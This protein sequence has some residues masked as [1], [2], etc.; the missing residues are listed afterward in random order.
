[1]ATDTSSTPRIVIFDFGGVLIDWNPRYVFR[2]LFETE[3]QMEWF[4]SN[5]C[6]SDWNEE[7]DAG[8]PIAKATEERIALWPEYEDLI[9][10]Y[11]GRWVE[12][13]GGPLTETVA[14][15][16]ELKDR[17]TPLYGLTNW[18]AETFPYVWEN[19]PYSTFL[20]WFDGIVVSGRVGLKKPDPAIYQ[21]LFER[22]DITPEEAFFIDDS[23]RNIAAAAKTGLHVW[24]FTDAASLRAELVRLGLL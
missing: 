13:L 10:A 7:Q 12:M 6:T 5:V 16:K 4:F 3:E 1:M 21:T 20:H 17:R 18:S 19:E 22:Y 2:S 23:A 8:Y 24:H 9:R 14:I 15:L 11:Y